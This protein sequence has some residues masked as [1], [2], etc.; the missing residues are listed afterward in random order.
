MRRRKVINNPKSLW[1]FFQWN[2]RLS[3]WP[4]VDCGN[5]M[6]NGAAFR[7]RKIEPWMNEWNETKIWWKWCVTFLWR[8]KYNFTEFF[9]FLKTK[10]N[11]LEWI[12]VSRWIGLHLYW[13][14]IVQWN[15]QFT[16]IALGTEKCGNIET[17]QKHLEIFWNFLGG[18]S[19]F[20]IFFFWRGEGTMGQCT[21]TMTHN[22]SIKVYS[23]DE[24]ESF[25]KKWKMTESFEGGLVN[26]NYLACLWA[27]F[28][29]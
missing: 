20:L 26:R 5:E 16:F 22:R 27:Y 23:S 4:S 14:E 6:C 12:S 2:C 1:F 3:C 8:V 13:S 17:T 7:E 29:R 21:H 18:K 10:K 9:C 11:S 28:I 25:W 24:L 15:Q 19:I